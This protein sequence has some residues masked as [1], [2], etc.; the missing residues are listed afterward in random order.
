[1]REQT[2]RRAT[3]PSPH[4]PAAQPRATRLDPPVVCPRFGFDKYIMSCN[5]MPGQ[6]Q[7]PIRSSRDGSSQYN[8]SQAKSC[9][10]VSCEA[11]SRQV[12][13]RQSKPNQSKSCHFMPSNIMSCLVR[14][15]QVKSDRVTS[16]HVGSCHAM[17]CL[18]LPFRLRFPGHALHE[19]GFKR[20]IG[21]GTLVSSQERRALAVPLVN[22]GL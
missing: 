18:L 2:R 21:V 12:K 16:S 13:S 11:K 17:L 9:Q 5:V 3:L 4:R 8:S 19:K 20:Q 10:V 15:K 14:F 22:C 1:M 6:V 7:P